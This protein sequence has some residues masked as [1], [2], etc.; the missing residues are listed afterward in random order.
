[1]E[2]PPTPFPFWRRHIATV[3]K[4]FLRYYML[5]LLAA[6][7]LSGSEIMETIKEETDGRWKP[8]PG[9][10]YPLLSL[11][12]DRGYVEELP[13]DKS[14]KKRYQITKQGKKFLE[15]Q[16]KMREGDKKKPPLFLGPFLFNHF[17][18]DIDPEKRAE[19]RK[20]LGRLLKSMFHLKNAMIENPTNETSEE[21]K[22]LLD[23]IAKR[24]ETT[25][26]K[27]GK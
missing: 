7:P 20:S 22:D 19:V 17:K 18:S 16:E 12:Q 24:I 25:T 5:K 13:K 21:V 11:L 27:L 15:G 26:K 6:K 14:G 10:V 9:S 1:M 3:P 4:G 8:S 23:S 2:L